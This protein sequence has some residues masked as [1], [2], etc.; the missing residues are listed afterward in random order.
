MTIKNLLQCA[1]ETLAP[2]PLARLEAE[3]LLCH[4]LEVSRSFLFANPDLEVP[5]KKR[6]DFLLLLHR[7][8]Q[9]EP[10]AYV[11]GKRSFW[12]FDVTVTP[13]VLIP[14]PETELLVELALDRIPLNARWRI[15]DIGTG[16]GA[17]AL[18]IASERPG[19][20]IHATDLSDKALRIARENS[21]RLK[22]EQVH[23][24]PGSWLQPLNGRFQ[25]LV[26]NP[27]Y[28]PQNDPHLQQGDC[29]YEPEIALSPGADG[30]AAIREII[31]QSLGK[32]E[33]GGWL[34]IEH[35]HDQGEEV[36]KLF[37]RFGL[38]SVN[39]YADLAGMDRVC[40]GQISIHAKA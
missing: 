13:D 39:T 15:A 12:T 40:A 3:I 25:V 21:A 1:R 7:R 22:L 29:R 36:R 23:F 17:I 37:S 8:S 11:V 19:C 34:L 5:L 9:G 35:G 31:L 28:V 6:A 16:S 24:H 30:L 33:V 27:P 18:A 2:D 4:A 14:R 10:M 32:L 26:S 38:E 20:E